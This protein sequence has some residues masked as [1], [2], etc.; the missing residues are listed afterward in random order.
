MKD[1][2]SDKDSNKK[3]V[4]DI[5]QGKGL[6]ESMKRHNFSFHNLFAAVTEFIHE[7]DNKP[8]RR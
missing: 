4:K 2:S 7:K 6:T 8:A 1:K 3:F 5:L